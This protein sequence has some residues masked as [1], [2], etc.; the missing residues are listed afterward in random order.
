MFSN[1][2]DRAFQGFPAAH[3]PKNKK[4]YISTKQS[5]VSNH[6]VICTQTSNEKTQR[7]KSK[8]DELT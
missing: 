8:W 2:P 5:S 6:Q 4:S 3:I 7:Y 1:T